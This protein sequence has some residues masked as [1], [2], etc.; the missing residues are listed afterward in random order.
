MIFS[1][2]IM[3]TLDV[4]FLWISL[5]STLPYSYSSNQVLSDSLKPKFNK[6]LDFDITDTIWN[7]TNDIDDMIQ[8]GE[9]I[10]CVNRESVYTLDTKNRRLIP[11]ING[12]NIQRDEEDAATRLAILHDKLYVSLLDNG[13]YQYDVTKKSWNRI[14][15]GMLDTDTTFFDLISCNG[16]LYAP[17]HD[18]GLYALNEKK[19]AWEKVKGENA[20]GILKC[21]CLDS[22]LW[23]G[24]IANDLYILSPKSGQLRKV[25]R[26]KE[27]EWV[28]RSMIGAGITGMMNKGDTLYMGV[29]VSGMF[30]ST[31]GG[32]TWDQKRIKFVVGPTMMWDGFLLMSDNWGY[33]KGLFILDPKTDE[34][35][36]IELGLGDVTVE[37]MK[38]IGDTF[39]LAT[40]N[41]LYTMPWVDFRKYYLPAGQ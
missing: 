30:K 3:L 31:D 16:T 19:L 26:F 15:K 29:H 28:E 27:P 1:N 10:F 24:T 7:R 23:V 17:A 8:F 6:I 40:R 41:S 32:R 34:F 20:Y 33:R 25:K 9:E 14:K 37:F 35:H 13:I 38:C 36:K 18:H 12:M 11:C 21:A 2:F 5:N 4:V 39:Y 22:V